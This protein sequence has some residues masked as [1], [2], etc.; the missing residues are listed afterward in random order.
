MCLRW[1]AAISCGVFLLSFLRTFVLLVTAILILPRFWGITG[2]WLAIPAA[3]ILAFMV[4]LWFVG[5]Q[6]RKG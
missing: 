1:V 6:M 2:V 4:S 5:K 3:E